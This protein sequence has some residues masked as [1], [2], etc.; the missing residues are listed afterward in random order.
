MHTCLHVYKLDAGAKTTPGQGLVVLVARQRGPQLFKRAGMRTLSYQDT[1]LS[2]LLQLEQKHRKGHS[3]YGL[4]FRLYWALRVLNFFH[5]STLL[6]NR[7]CSDCSK[8]V[9]SNELSVL[10]APVDPLM[11]GREDVRSSEDAYSLMLYSPTHLSFNRTPSTKSTL[12]PSPHVVVR[13]QP[14]EQ[15]GGGGRG[16]HNK[17]ATN[18][19]SRIP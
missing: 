3:G 12:N 19:A 18:V 6:F 11:S 17:K 2:E 13:T 7:G 16:G 10:D 14:Q 4:G 1:L 8:L 5:H 9:V 15:K